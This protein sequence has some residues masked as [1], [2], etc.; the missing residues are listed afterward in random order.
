RAT[1]PRRSSMRFSLSGGSYA[2]PRPSCVLHLWRRNRSSDW[3]RTFQL[4]LLRRLEQ[5]IALARL[6]PAF[7]DLLRPVT[8]DLVAARELAQLWNLVA[9]TSRLNERAAGVE[10]TGRRRIRRAGK[11]ACKEDCLALP[12]HHGVR[13]RH[14][15]E[16]RD[17]VRVQ[18]V[19]VELLRCG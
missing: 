4:L 10:P 14:G 1:C 18:R 9:A 15:R 6:D 2:G 11:V 19:L 3:R 16:Q 5:S 7:L 12:L 8:R 13:D 17:R